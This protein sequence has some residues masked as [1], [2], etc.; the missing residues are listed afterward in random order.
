MILYTKISNC[1]AFWDQVNPKKSW[2]PHD[3]LISGLLYFSMDSK[4]AERVGFEPTYRLITG[5]S[6]SSR[7]RYGRFATSPTTFCIAKTGIKGKSCLWTGVCFLWCL[8]PHSA[9]KSLCCTQG[10]HQRGM[11][12]QLRPY[13]VPC[14]PKN[15]GFSRAAF[16]WDMALNRFVISCNQEKIFWN[17][18]Y[19]HLLS[20]ALT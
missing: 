1:T 7:A 17:T 18:L 6:I 3:C 19:W 16:W 14:Q 4:M 8:G 9:A 13:L 12:N 15:I 2:N 11:S 10:K 5:N 20:R